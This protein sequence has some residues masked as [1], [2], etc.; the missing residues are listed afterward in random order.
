MNMDNSH[1]SINRNS[2]GMN[3]DDT[4]DE[5]V[6]RNCFGFGMKYESTDEESCADEG[7]SNFPINFRCEKPVGDGFIRPR[8][9]PSFQFI[10]KTGEGN[11]HHRKENIIHN[12][13][14]FSDN[15]GTSSVSCDEE[16]DFEVSSFVV[17][18]PTTHDAS[19]GAEDTDS[20]SDS[21]DASEEDSLDGAPEEYEDDADDDATDEGED[22]DSSV[23]SDT[24]EDEEAEEDDGRNCIVVDWNPSIHE[25]D[26]MNEQDDLIPSFA[27]KVSG[28]F[29]DSSDEES[30]SAEVLQDVIDKSDASDMCFSEPEDADENALAYSGGIDLNRATSLKRSFNPDED[31]VAV[32]IS[33][34]E[35][36]SA[37]KRNCRRLPLEMDTISSKQPPY[38]PSLSLGSPLDM[39]L[40]KSRGSP[41]FS[42]DDEV[43]DSQL[44]DELIDRIPGSDGQE[45]SSPVPLLTPPGTPVSHTTDGQETLCEWPS[46]LAVDVAL[47]S[48]IEMP[49]SSL[50]KLEANGATTPNFL[51][52]TS[53]RARS[54]SEA[55]STLTP[56][57]N[58]LGM[59]S[60]L[61]C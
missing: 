25:E 20:D 41:Q 32:K 27:T 16:D 49:L 26:R 6:K 57:L 15:D 23:S 47:T 17:A 59:K 10:K 56:L 51:P 19:F 12:E 7:D 44:A 22:S 39:T 53:I 34:N 55:S 29:S 54:V 40:M 5:E 2:N 3:M 24:D 43:V 33:P 13:C 11:L 60:R 50:A 30:I 37:Y 14:E 36:S 18:S 42:S 1:S 4:E 9:I 58:S 45:S 61:N 52:P 48:A 46:N 38:F 28:S 31:Q 35:N 21:D 8:P